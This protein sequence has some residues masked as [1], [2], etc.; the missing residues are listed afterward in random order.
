MT[1]AAEPRPPRP[2]DLA[3]SGARMLTG[4]LHQ[5]WKINYKQMAPGNKAKSM[6]LM[7]IAF[8]VAIAT[9]DGKPHTMASLSKD[10]EIPPATLRDLVKLLVRYKRVQM[11]AG[12]KRGKGHEQMIVAN[13]DFLDSLM[14]IQHVKLCIETIET[15][16][17][18]LKLLSTAM[19]PQLIANGKS[20]VSGVILTAWP[21]MDYV[22]G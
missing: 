20:G 2:A 12:R 7:G 9:A 6:V 3:V 18:E 21:A 4:L 22:F 11:I 13:L 10:I 16:L 14:T 1:P 5:I 17:N 8:R 15:C 19:M